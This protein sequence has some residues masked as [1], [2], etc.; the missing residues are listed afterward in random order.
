MIKYSLNAKESMEGEKVR[1][2]YRVKPMDLANAGFV[3]SQIK[4]ELKKCGVEEDAVKRVGV[5]CFEAEMNMILYSVG[6]KII[7]EAHEDA[8]EIFAEDN[9]PGI[10]DLEKAMQ[11]GYSTAPLWAQDY[12]F[13]AGMGF[14]NMKQNS[15]VFEVES[16]PGVGTKIHATVYRRKKNEAE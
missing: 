6:G 11:P 3:S 13:G 9:G 2:V 12:G 1:L 8:I 15:D 14:P 7:V 16:T 5:V 10:E 4:S